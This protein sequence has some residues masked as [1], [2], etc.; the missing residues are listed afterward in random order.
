MVVVILLEIA[1]RVKGP[2]RR[3][4]APTVTHLLGRQASSPWVNALRGAWFLEVGGAGWSECRLGGATA[5]QEMFD[6]TQRFLDN[7]G[8][9]DEITAAV[10]SKYVR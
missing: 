1:V 2:S 4:L 8:R 3:A 7:K 9:T 5:Q 6:T 10:F